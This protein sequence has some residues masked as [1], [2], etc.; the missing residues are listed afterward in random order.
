MGCLGCEGATHEDFS[1]EQK[2]SSIIDRLCINRRSIV[3]ENWF[4]GWRNKVK[5]GQIR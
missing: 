1:E 3:G 5:I 4:D 2:R